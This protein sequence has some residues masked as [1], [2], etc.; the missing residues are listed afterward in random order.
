MTNKLVLTAFLSLLIALILSTSASA[1][2]FRLYVCGYGNPTTAPMSE[3]WWSGAWGQSKQTSCGDRAAWTVA[4]NS[5]NEIPNFAFGQ[6]G[7]AGQQIAAPSGT[8]FSGLQMSTNVR[9]QGGGGRCAGAFRADG[10]LIEGSQNC[11]SNTF[12]LGST[13]YIKKYVSNL[14]T[15]RLYLLAFCTFGPCGGSSSSFSADFDNID[16]RLTDSTYPEI[17][18]PSGLA[19]QNGWVHGSWPVGFTA[20]DGFGVRQN[21]LLVGSLQVGTS[22]LCTVNRSS[23]GY[24]W[25]YSL[26]SCPSSATAGFTLNTNTLAS[27]KRVLKMK[28]VDLTGNYRYIDKTIAVDNTAPIVSSVSTK[29]PKSDNTPLINIRASD[30]LSGISAYYCKIDG[31]L[32]Q[33]CS[34]NFTA[35]PLTNGGHQICVKVANNSRNA[36]GA[37]LESAERCLNV[38]V[39]SETPSQ[40]ERPAADV[41]NFSGDSNSSD[42]LVVIAPRV[43]ANGRSVTLATTVVLSREAVINQTIVNRYGKRSLRCSTVEDGG[44]VGANLIECRMGRATRKLLR[45]SGLTVL[46]TTTATFADGT[47]ASEVDSLPLRRRP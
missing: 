6:G 37:A 13:G 21:L 39:D 33:S 22:S 19:T 20:S 45:K 2:S 35:P 46:V 4:W 32:Y 12:S 9:S 27:G 44:E 17:S 23:S 1:G 18:A 40:S 36:T 11:R 47:V 24:Y 5:T 7:A 14:N 8:Y 34:A 42:G 43:R 16:L 29:S 41:G 25:G 3:V 15:D 30:S 31:S 10:S 26:N 28:S 38:N